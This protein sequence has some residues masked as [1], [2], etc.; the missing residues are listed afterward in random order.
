VPDFTVVKY[1]LDLYGRPVLMTAYMRD[2]FEGYCYEL[3]WIPRI[4]QGAY[5][6]QLGGGAI[7]SQ[8]AHD[9]GKCLDLETK[10]RSTAEIDLMVKT[11]R[12]GGAGAYRRDD[13]WRHGS[14][15]QHMHL[16]LGSD[17]PGSPMADTLWASYLGGGDGLAIEPPQPDYEW[18]PSPL[19]LTPPADWSDD[20][21]FTDWPQADKDALTAAVAAA[22]L[23]ATVDKDGTVTVKQALNQIRNAEKKAA[24]S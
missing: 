23:A 15:P 3:G 7:A 4:A 24:G 17:A 2:W 20:M 12:D 19:V 21:P 11:A 16:T 14:M 6:S 1:G 22:V 13:T 18:R 8:G 10:G 5:M 9:L